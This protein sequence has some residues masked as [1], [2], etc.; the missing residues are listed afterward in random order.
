MPKKI[1][2][3]KPLDWVNA[4]LSESSKSIYFEKDDEGHIKAIPVIV[5]DPAGTY[6]DI[7]SRLKGTAPTG[8][9][10]YATVGSGCAVYYDGNSLGLMA[11]AQQYVLDPTSNITYAAR[12]PN[13][14]KSSAIAAAPATTDLWTPAAG[15]AFRV[16]GGVICMSGLIAAAATRS[17]T[18]IEETAGT[19]IMR[20]QA[21]IPV[22]GFNLCIP[23]DLKPNGFLATAVNKKLQVVTA[24]GTYSTGADS[25]AVW[26]TEETL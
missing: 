16:M 17:L 15:K 14:W 11:L 24:G 20:A 2:F 7:G 4:G 5:F 9:T 22:L 21:T 13:T 25:V 23:F 10:G 12:T 3:N 1:V 8:S 6:A 18:L 19:V 26:G